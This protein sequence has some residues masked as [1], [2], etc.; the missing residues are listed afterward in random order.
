MRPTFESLWSQ[1]VNEIAIALSSLHQETLRTGNKADAKLTELQREHQELLVLFKEKQIDLDRTNKEYNRISQQYKELQE[2]ADP[3]TCERLK[4]ERDM[5][6]SYSE[7]MAEERSRFAG[8]N[9]ALKKQVEQLTTEARSNAK[10]IEL[11]RSQLEVI[12]RR[13][14][15]SEIRDTGVSPE[16]RE[17]P[18]RSVRGFMLIPGGYLTTL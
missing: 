9:F 14:A 8:D 1:S 5:A 18:V 15:R 4:A 12:Q 13:D 7:K 11:L 2:V 10:E 3:G 6:K 17:A 16:R